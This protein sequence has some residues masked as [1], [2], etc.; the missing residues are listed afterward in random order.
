MKVAILGAGFLGLTA[1]IR[2]AQ[3]GHT[4]VVFEKNKTAGGL[5]RGFSLPGWQWPLDE[6]YHHLF[7]SDSSIRRLAREI[8]QTLI[9]KQP[10]T[11]VYLKGR[12]RQFDSPFSLLCFPYLSFFSRLRTGFVLAYLKV[13]PWWQMLEGVT[14]KDFLI[15]FG[16]RESWDV[17][18]EPLFSA[19]F[20]RFSK[21]VPASWFWARIKKRS[22][23]LGYPNAGFG[24]MAH[25]MQRVASERGVVFRF[26]LGVREIGVVL[27]LGKLS[28][29]TE[30][31]RQHL[32]DKIICTLPTPAFVKIAHLLLD[33]KYEQSFSGLKALGAVNLVLVLTRPFFEDGTYWLNINEKGFPFLAVVEH[34]N[35]VD[36][37]HYGGRH[38]VYVGN[39]KDPTDSLFGLASG[40]LVDM[41]FPYLQKISPG[42]RRSSI[43]AAF[44]SRAPFAQPV[45]PLFYSRRISSVETPVKG[46]FLANM[47]Q[48]YPWDRGTNYAVSLGEKVASLIGKNAW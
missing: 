16:G 28:V 7:V 40:Q 14:A 13:F 29:K 37:T 6:H 43:Q 47:Q 2:L 42:F 10:K 39:Y 21:R 20:G 9:F 25:K 4:V 46:L 45:I 34:T 32:F 17:L 5:A 41:F 19:K 3:M 48:V 23:S 12:I 24:G 26:G 8:G 15:R 33:K 27:R 36:K 38:I 18:W 44:V 35:L 31:G 30:G 11:S 22:L 1:A